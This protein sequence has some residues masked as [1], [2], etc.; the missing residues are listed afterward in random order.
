MLRTNQSSFVVTPCHNQR[1]TTAY[2]GAAVYNSSVTTVFLDSVTFLWRDGNTGEEGKE[3][4][5]CVPVQLCEVG[6]KRA[7]NAYLGIPNSHGFI[8]RRR[9]NNAERTREHAPN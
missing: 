6:G 3:G 8:S 7:G 2:R 1:R 5:M 4:F 9:I